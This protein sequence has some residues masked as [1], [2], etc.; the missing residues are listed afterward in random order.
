MAEQIRLDLGIVPKPIDRC[1]F[2]ICVEIVDEESAEY[3]EIKESWIDIE[4]SPMTFGDLVGYVQDGFNNWS[5][6]DGSGWLHTEADQDYITG[7]YETKS[8]H[9][10]NARS[11]RYLQKAYKYVYPKG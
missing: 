11:E 1:L 4:D 9:P 8:L 3:G 2:S 5:C 7:E 6:S 10:K